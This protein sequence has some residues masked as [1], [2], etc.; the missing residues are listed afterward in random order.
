MSGMSFPPPS[1]A[2]IQRVV[3][4]VV[5]TASPLRIVLFGSAARGELRD[6]S[7]LD[8]MVVV[9][10]GSDTLRVAQ[11]LYVEMARRRGVQSFP[12]VD[13]VVS[14]PGRYEDRKNSLGSVYREVERD[15]RELY[16]A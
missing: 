12:C 16:A 9:G 7:D 14:T 10:E 15:G 1:E 6:G 13:F 4:L 5:E 11:R 2:D 8:I 3:Q